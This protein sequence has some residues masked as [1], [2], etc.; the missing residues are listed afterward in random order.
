MKRKEV[1][2]ED[3]KGLKENE[4]LSKQELALIADIESFLK[5]HKCLNIKRYYGGVLLSHIAKEFL[6][7]IIDDS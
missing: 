4:K 2:L 1:I 5:S 3:L 6:N 7:R